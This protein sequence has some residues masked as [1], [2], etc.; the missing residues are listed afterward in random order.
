MTDKKVFY[1]FREKAKNIRKPHEIIIFTDGFSYSAT[2][3]FIKE[4]QLRGGAIIV[5]F[6]GNPENKYLIQVWLLLL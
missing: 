1:E 2:S 3:I 4:T 6:G 5:G